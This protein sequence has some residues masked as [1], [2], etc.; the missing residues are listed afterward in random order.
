MSSIQISKTGARATSVEGVTVDFSE[1]LL[2]EVAAGY[3][4]ALHEAPLVIGHPSLQAPAYGWVRG[5]S[6]A[7]GALVAKAD[8][9][10]QLVD[11]VRQQHV[12]KVSASFY[13]PTAANNPT[14]GKW[15]LRHVGFLGAAPPAVKGLAPVSFAEGDS[16]QVE[17]D[18]QAVSFGEL[19]GYFG[20]GV[21]RLLRRLRDWMV[22]RDGAERADAVLPQWELDNLG[23]TAAAATQEEIDERTQE[24]RPSSGPAS[25]ADPSRA[26]S[27]S[28]NPLANPLANPHER[29]SHVSADNQAALAAERARAD[30]AEAE[31]NALRSAE[32]ARQAQA[33]QAECA[34]FADRMVSE[35]RWPA[36]ARDVLVSTLVHLET[37]VGEA[38]VSFGEGDAAQP[39]A[40][41]LREQLQSLPPAVSFAE[42]ARAGAAR[43]TLDPV[44]LGTKAAALVEEKATQGITM[45]AAEAV[46]QL[47]QQGA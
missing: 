43:A 35:A 40:A 15:Y 17:L 25:F 11:L 16:V 6:F 37:P 26:V 10:P 32:A 36:G 46:A 7:D 14:P 33:R 21:H 31:L 5:L 28:L 18:V 8:P 27:A 12:K 9:L 24:S 47:Q 42:H 41:V 38:A 4:P 20:A 34:S 29:N 19:P 13:P 39:L 1:Q 23:E 45:S 44:A 22:E 30:R 3:D 2:A